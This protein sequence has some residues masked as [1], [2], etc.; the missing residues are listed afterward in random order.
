MKK[1]LPLTVTLFFAVFLAW[2][3]AELLKGAFTDS[4]RFSLRYFQLIFDNPFYSQCFLNSALI[5]VWSTLLALAVAL[6]LAWLFNRCEFPA[7]T[8][9]N[10]L[11]LLPL[12]LPPFVGAIGLRQFFT[13]YGTLNLLLEKTGL[14]NLADP[15]DWLASGGFY[16]IILL[17]AL[18]LYPILFLSAQAAMANLDPALREAAA[19]L[20]ARGWRVFR[21]VT[22][23]LAL[24]GIF[25]GTTIVF[26]AA[27]TDLGVPLMFSFQATV[28]SQIF[29]LVTQ[30]DNPLG[31]ALVALTLL[32][33]ALL[34][35]LG[36][37]LGGGG[38][39]AAMRGGA[40][41]LTVRLGRLPALLAT[42]GVL[43]LVAVSV[44]PHLGVVLQSFSARWFMTALPT[45][46]SGQ[47]YREVFQLDATAL[48]VKNSL[49]YSVC[50]MSL[51]LVLGL[52]IA[53]LLTR[54]KF[55]GKAL[56]DTAAMLPLALPGLVLAFAY[57]VTFSKPGSPLAFLDPRGNPLPL[58]VIAYAMHRL[59]YIV[60]AAYAGFQQVST[61]LEEA[62]TNLGARAW[63]TFRRVSLPLIMANLVAGSIL[64]FSFAMLDVSNSLMLAQE[65]RFYPITKAIYSLMGR[66]TP[67]A[68]NVACALGVLALL[69][70]AAALYLA[71]R[72]MG[73]KMGQ[74]FRS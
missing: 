20:G 37:R 47:F 36:K 22:L 43:G 2:P 3:L 13:R 62:S 53:W 23:P 45:E 9:L 57:Y 14:V 34:F 26:I 17:Q 15:P 69:L 68:P 5:A 21:T 73:Q 44:I 67:T 71:A 39:A 7:K 65:S 16:G 70:L 49:L 64:T 32:L 10:S 60:R 19:N 59:P 29:N 24:P 66:I 30:P 48:S 72:L 11:L 56:L 58:L 25:A 27:F 28:P 12:I 41:A 40:P 1:L 74:L 52:A 63:Q 42:A 18:H 31:Y 8:L 33:V 6:P 35:L 55:R 38:H 46:W 51:D 4:G 50:S 61:A 54:E